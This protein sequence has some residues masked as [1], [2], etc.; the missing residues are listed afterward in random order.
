MVINIKKKKNTCKKTGKSLKQN[1]WYLGKIVPCFNEASSI[2]N[3]RKKKHSE[4]KFAC[5]MQKILGGCR[6]KRAGSK[7]KMGGKN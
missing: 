3:A 2:N 5:V 1:K 4:T 7:E 6:K